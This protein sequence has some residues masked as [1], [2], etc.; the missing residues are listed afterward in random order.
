MEA[1]HR[2]ENGVLQSD[3]G[4]AY[5]SA[6]FP[7]FE[8]LERD[9]PYGREPLTDKVSFPITHDC[10]RLQVY[11]IL[12]C[13]ASRYQFLLVDFQLLRHSEAVIC[14]HPV[15]CLLH[16]MFQTLLSF[17]TQLFFPMVTC[18]ITLVGFHLFFFLLCM[19][20]I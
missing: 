15:G 9:P 5:V 6:S 13:M 10:Y 18:F 2:L 16:G 1:T 8:H 17:F 12:L 7:I 20:F 19:L 11:R 4:E 14:C 3:D